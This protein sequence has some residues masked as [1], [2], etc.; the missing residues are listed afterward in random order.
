[1]K[2]WNIKDYWEKEYLEVCRNAVKSDKAFQT[3]KCQQ[4]YLRIVNQM[5]KQVADEYYR[6]IKK[7]YPIQL[8]FICYF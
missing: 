7:H 2:N 6:F 5:S 1:M 4:G 8:F 3:F